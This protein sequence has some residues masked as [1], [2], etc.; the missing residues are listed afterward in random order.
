MKQ[1]NSKFFY[2]N[3][4]G[5]KYLFMPLVC[6]ISESAQTQN[7]GINT[8][9]P[10]AT[11]DVRGTQRV[12]GN[13]NY[14]QYDSA[15]G[16][17]EWVGASLFTPV[18]QQII[19]HSASGEGLYAGGGKL[20]YRNSIGDPVFYSDWTNGN[21]YFSGNLG[22]GTTDAQTKMH[23]FTGASGVLPYAQ[24]SPLAV[25]SNGHT[26]I[27][28]LSPASS[29]T[30]ILF[31]SGT[32]TNGVIMYNNTSTP[33]GFQFRNNGNLTR[34][35]IDNSG[36]VG[37]GIIT[38]SAYG[39]GGNN[40][41]LEI[42]N[43]NTGG[44]IQSHLILSSNGTSGSNGGITWASQN[45]PGPEKRLGFIGNVYETSNAARMVFYTRNESGN[46]S[47]GFT[48]LGNG[49]I[50]IGTATPN[51]PLS[52]P[53]LLGKKITLYPG[54]T[55]DVGMAVQ[56]NLLQIYSDNPGADIAFGYDQNGTMTESM[57]IKGNGNVG[58]GNTNPQLK[59]DINGSMR[60]SGNAPNSP[61]IWLYNSGADR[62]LVGLESSSYVGFYG[63]PTGWK[64][65]MN[66]QSG[67]LKINGSE[68]TSGQYLKSNGAGQPPVWS[69]LF[70]NLFFEQPVSSSMGLLSTYQSVS[71]IHMQQFT[72]PPNSKLIITITG[73]VTTPGNNG[74]QRPRLLLQILDPG[75]FVLDPIIEAGGFLTQGGG[76]GDY[77]TIS[78][79]Q[80]F[81]LPAA[82]YT[83]SCYASKKDDAGSCDLS[84]T[85]VIIQIIPL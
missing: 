29:E 82:T 33:N 23:V 62:A 83:L 47:E 25:E 12:G 72:V 79:S 48:L 32:S 76:F 11:M 24:F 7:V 1:I 66:T 46:L 41:I 28:L 36:N 20:D 14:M 38:A 42:N 8:T 56:G 81:T 73:N 22:V 84:Q 43:P 74:E 6:I 10:Q 55:G 51:A 65:C 63:S 70:Q 39:H 35:V 40:R 15:T 17:I 78:S 4:L 64:F 71:N 27:N 53:P 61:G 68:G 59:L 2:N 5:M 52:F 13:S 21:G 45:V 57:R 67:A 49:N 44:D 34:M 50:G 58:I 30:A 31:G 37:I 16:R 80:V 3:F 75:G 9:T 18:S 26:Y 85:K 54:A 69:N 19:K 77:Q 60:L